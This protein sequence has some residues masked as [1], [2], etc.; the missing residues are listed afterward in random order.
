[1]EY[2]IVGGDNYIT[3]GF[4]RTLGEAGIPVSA[5]IIRRDHP[6]ASNSAILTIT[7]ECYIV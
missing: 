6:F 4:I 2:L 7:V 1:M 5:I 3:L